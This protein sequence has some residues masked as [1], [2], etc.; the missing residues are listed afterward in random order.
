MQ[1]GLRLKNI[2]NTER[3]GLFLPLA[4]LIFHKNSKEAIRMTDHAA[5]LADTS[6]EIK[7]SL[8]YNLG[9]M[10]YKKFQ[11]QA[12]AEAFQKAIDVNLSEPE[13][14]AK[15]HLWLGLSCKSL[16]LPL[17]AYMTYEKGLQ[18]T[19][20]SIPIRAQLYAAK[21]RVSYVL[22][23]DFSPIPLNNTTRMS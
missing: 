21:E 20:I 7:A 1:E 14:M 9:Q 5:A 15:L 4:A 3:A 17:Q 8:Y 18:F 22:K 10:L 19:P 2:T 23:K 13:L 12:A 6:K 16:S 11:F